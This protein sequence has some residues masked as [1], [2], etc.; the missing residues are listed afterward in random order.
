VPQPGQEEKGTCKRERLKE[1]TLLMA[2]Q[3][4][5][6]V[7]KELSGWCPKKDSVT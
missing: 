1:M 2:P 3:F 5:E 4:P 6:R 7:D